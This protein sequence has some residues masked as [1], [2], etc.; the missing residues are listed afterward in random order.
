MKDGKIL[1][2]KK[3]HSDAMPSALGA[4]AANF[5]KNINKSRSNK[6]SISKRRVDWHIDKLTI[7]SA[8]TV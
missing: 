7:F 8:R 2:N 3:F 1:G 6:L 4:S 5:N